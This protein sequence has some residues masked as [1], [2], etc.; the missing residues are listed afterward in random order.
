MRYYE[1]HF[2]M[3]SQ[4]VTYPLEQWTRRRLRDFDDKITDYI[5]PSRRL[6]VIVN[7][8]LIFEIQ[9]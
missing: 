7:F 3:L 1:N 5:V 2:D 4:S 9:F 8:D 6:V